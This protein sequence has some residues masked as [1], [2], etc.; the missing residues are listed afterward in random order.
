VSERFQLIFQSAGKEVVQTFEQ[1]RVLIGRSVVCDLVFDSLHLSRKHAEIVR[2]ADGW[3]VHDLGSRHGLAVNGAAVTGRKLSPGDRIALAPEAAEPTVME[4]RPADAAGAAAPRLFLGDDALT[5]NIIASIDLR[6]LAKS[7]SESGRVKPSAEGKVMGGEQ[8]APSSG[9]SLP[10]PLSLPP[11]GVLPALG[12]L[13]SAGEALLA[14]ESLDDMLQPMADLIGSHLPGRRVAIC[15]S[16]PSSGELAP[17]C[18]SRAALPDESASPRPFPIS[19]S[20]LQ[21][22]IRVRRAL[23]V[24][25]TADDSRLVRA[26]SIRQIG[27]RSAIC[28]PL[29][30]EGRVEGAVY[31]D[32]QRE[33]ATL[34]GGELEV[35]TVLGLMLAAGIVQMSLRGEVARER[36]VRGRLARYNSPQVVEQIMQSVKLGSSLIHAQPGTER[37]LV[38]D[39]AGESAMSPL[40]ADAM[41]ADEYDV[42]VLFA[43]LG[44]FT[45]LAERSSAAEAVQVLNMVFE[46]WTADVFARDGTLDKYIGDAVMA[47]FG[48]PLRQD[49]HARRAVATA[50]A[51]RQ[52]LEAFNRSRPQEQPLT[53]RIGI[54]S[55]RV[56]AGDIGSPMHRAYT[57]IG[58]AV[59]VASRLEASVAQPGEIII[60]EAT[61]QQLDG[62]YACEP[63]GPV[64]L[65]GKRRV[66]EAYRVVGT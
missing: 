41:L 23:L 36:A 39:L 13:K 17:R 18:F 10:A 48:A 52:S 34:S 7:L 44:G 62:A 8:G 16:D 61:Y 20:I 9:S 60:G 26:P 42:S 29:Y 65:R 27:I 63:L 55:G 12:L 32:S 2:E 38:A 51:M 33:F 19:R 31:V 54:N 59:N 35:L 6:E 45:P 3:S 56:I 30:H 28:V 15:T 5:T 25:N 58:D 64:Q 47:V 57:V 22:A 43:D 53:V 1:P 40:S 11:A 50:L 46:R 4:F 66:V 49:D 24:A 21:E 37:S 14:H